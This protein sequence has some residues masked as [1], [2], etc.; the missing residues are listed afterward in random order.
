MFGYGLLRLVDGLDGSHGPGLA[1]NVGHCLFLLAFVLFGVLVVGLRRLVANTSAVRQLVA[2]FAT[3]AG[4]VGVFAFLRVIVGDLFPGTDGILELPE[5]LRMAGPPLF[6]V[7]LVTLLSQLVGSE[8]NRLPRWSPAVV[9]LGF[10]P[11]AADLDL[12]C[13]GAVLF[14]A[15]L[16]PLART[17]RRVPSR[18]TGLP[19]LDRT[20]P[21]VTDP[22]RK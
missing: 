11:I 15:G 20:E 18:R 7:G 17:S 16:M 1:W 13:V 8:P 21:P 3:A 6:L 5:V 22:T 9:F 10:V 19:G 4:L 12:L 14:A 2:D